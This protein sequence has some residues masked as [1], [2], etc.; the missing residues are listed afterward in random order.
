[1]VSNNLGLRRFDEAGPIDEHAIVVS[2]ELSISAVKIAAG[3]GGEYLIVWTTGAGVSA[4]RFDANTGQLVGSTLDLVGEAGIFDV[5]ALVATSAGY[6]VIYNDYELDKLAARRIVGGTLQGTAGV[7]LA[8]LGSARAIANGS[9]VGVVTF[10]GFV[11]FD[12]AQDAVLDA[13]PVVFDRFAVAEF[14]IPGIAFDGTNYVLVWGTANDRVCAARIKASDGSLVDVPDEFNELPGAKQIAHSQAAWLEAWFDGTNV[15]ATWIE[16]VNFYYD[17]VGARVTTSLARVQGTSQAGPEFVLADTDT[18]DTFHVGVS[19]GWGLAL[20]EDG[21]GLRLDLPSGAAPIASEFPIGFQG[22]LHDALG[23]ASNGSDFL[24]SYRANPQDSIFVR[25]VSGSTGEPIGPQRLLAAHPIDGG[26]S[27]DHV[28]LAWSG[29]F[30][31][32]TWSLGDD[33]YFKLIHCDGTPH[34]GEPVLLGEGR[35]AR[36]ACNDDRCAIVWRL[37][38]GYLVKRLDAHSGAVLD[39]TALVVAGSGAIYPAQISSD[40]TPEPSLRTFLITWRTSTEVKARRLRSQGSLV[41]ETTIATAVTALSP[42]VASDGARFF[43]TWQV[44]VE[45]F[46]RFVDASTGLPQ[47]ANAT[48]YAKPSQGQYS[49]TA[50]TH[51]GSSFFSVWSD[52][53]A[54]RDVR[55]IRI[56]GSG[57]ALDGIG[58]SLT[59]QYHDGYAIAATPWGRSLLVYTGYDQPSFST[60]AVGRFHDNVLG[61]G[62][63]ARTFEC[64]DDGG[65]GGAGGQAGAATGEAGHAGSEPEGDGGMAGLA[66]GGDGTG[67][68][69]P[70]GGDGSDAGTSSGVAGSP[71]Q[72]G[73]AGNASSGGSDANGGSSSSAGSPSSAGKAGSSMTGGTNPSG[74][75]A[76]SPGSADSKD[77]GGCGCRVAGSTPSRASLVLLGAALAASFARRRKSLPSPTAC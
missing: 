2:E 48:S 24:V 3:S 18:Y 36:V 62:S 46:G 1:V 75:G 39:D 72:G 5:Q 15:V 29:T 70:Q 67:G 19:G 12:A 10:D 4:A 31:V 14:W 41:A 66:S 77:A 40:F 65:T 32:A 63:A 73:A 13:T 27:V 45:L 74:G 68:V 33:S 23:V 51:D 37:S 64:P 22:T 54:P 34:A 50:L 21:R 55:G 71:A 16:R 61:A 42:H 26:S 6:V 44:G 47:G 11:R 9:Q 17:L 35:D 53:M 69:G 57:A 59:G 76:G 25:A 28:S 58:V 60:I 49:D 20:V 7:P 43:V 56:D 30:Y 52:P 38:G 8:E